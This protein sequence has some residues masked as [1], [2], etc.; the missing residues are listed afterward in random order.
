M[1]HA[2]VELHSMSQYALRAK[3]AYKMKQF[4]KHFDKTIAS[5]IRNNVYHQGRI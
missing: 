5:I 2:N 1:K 3:L 4:Y